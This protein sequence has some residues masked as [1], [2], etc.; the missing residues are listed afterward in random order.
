MQTTFKFVQQSLLQNIVLS[1]NNCEEL[2]KQIDSDFELMQKTKESYLSI[3]E[4]A[5]AKFPFL[6]NNLNK[7]IFLTDNMLT[8]YKKFEKL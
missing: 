5:N 3:L 4:N 2:Y 6:I 7:E 1:E 8:K